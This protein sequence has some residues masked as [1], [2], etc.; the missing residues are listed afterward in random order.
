M[1]YLA[2][3]LPVPP[4]IKIKNKLETWHGA[5]CGECPNTLFIMKGHYST[6]T[7]LARLLSYTGPQRA[8]P[9]GELACGDR[10]GIVVSMGPVY[11]S[12]AAHDNTEA[13]GC[14]N[15]T[16]ER[17]PLAAML[18]KNGKSHPCLFYF[19]MLP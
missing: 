2:A 8:S 16:K 6:L 3:P 5:L 1:Y 17:G 18:N 10:L 14:Q 15:A 13:G 11:A 19:H 4:F 7:I 9:G 12:P